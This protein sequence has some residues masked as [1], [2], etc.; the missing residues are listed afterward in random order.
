MFKVH[1]IDSTKVLYDEFLTV[2]AVSII[3]GE[4]S[5]LFHDHGY[6]WY[7]DSAYKYYPA[8]S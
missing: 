4:T 1:P 8:P 7:W 2:Y 3:N 6:T 5:F